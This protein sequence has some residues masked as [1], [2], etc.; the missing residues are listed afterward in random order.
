MDLK[1]LIGDFRR[2]NPFLFNYLKNCKQT[3][4]LLDVEPFTENKVD[5]S[6]GE[7]E[8]RGFTEFT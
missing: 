2:S 8:S 1:H 7:S 6:K 3:I 4:A 5:Y